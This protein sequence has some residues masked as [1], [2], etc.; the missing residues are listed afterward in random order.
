[1]AR[2]ICV[3]LNNSIKALK[4]EGKELMGPIVSASATTTTTKKTIE[5]S[6]IVSLIEPQYKGLCPMLKLGL[7]QACLPHVL[8]G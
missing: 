2:R 6:R 1:M 3:R 5:I 7:S 4:R 8:P